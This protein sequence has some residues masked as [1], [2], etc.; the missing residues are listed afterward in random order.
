MSNANTIFI[1]FSYIKKK[2]NWLFLLILQTQ[3]GQLNLH[4]NVSDQRPK[5]ERRVDHKN[6]IAQFFAQNKKRQ[7]I[8]RQKKYQQIQRGKIIVTPIVIQFPI[9]DSKPWSTIHKIASTV[10]E[11]FD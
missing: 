10:A 5:R 8:K 6:F 2:L 1:D 4:Q 7:R 3:S 9:F 11:K